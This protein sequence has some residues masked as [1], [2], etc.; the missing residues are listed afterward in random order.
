MTPT[1]RKGETS[2]HNHCTLPAMNAATLRALVRILSPYRAEPISAAAV[3]LAHQL[4]R[5]E[6]AQ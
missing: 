3:T 1:K 4:A 2:M 6:V 5:L